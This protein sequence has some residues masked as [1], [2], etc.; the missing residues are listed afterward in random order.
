[1]GL[2]LKFRPHCECA[3]AVV[4]VVANLDQA[5]APGGIGMKKGAADAGVLVDAGGAVSPGAVPDEEFATAR[6]QPVRKMAAKKTAVC[7]SRSA[8]SHVS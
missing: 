8:R 7:P 5:A 3:D 6:K 4:E 2:F 1:L